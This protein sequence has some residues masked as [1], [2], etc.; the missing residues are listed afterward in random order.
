MNPFKNLI[1][2]LSATGIAA[3][4]SIALICITILG[5]FGSGELAKSAMNFL[6]IFLGAVMTSAAFLRRD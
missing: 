1:V 5:V 2:T 6:G 4:I 3:T